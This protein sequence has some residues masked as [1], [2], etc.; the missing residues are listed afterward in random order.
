MML[1][2]EQEYRSMAMQKSSGLSSMSFVNIRDSSAWKPWWPLTAWAPTL[3]CYDQHLSGR[4]EMGIRI[5]RYRQLPV[6]SPSI[7]IW[8]HS[9]IELLAIHNHSR[10]LERGS[11]RINIRTFIH[12]ITC[13]PAIIQHDRG[14]ASKP[15]RDDRTVVFIRPLLESV[16]RL[17]FR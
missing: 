13:R 11:T 4:R 9:L 17:R 7:P 5:W 16:P 14:I 2:T 10:N 1:T 3:K 6:Q 8:Q 15:H 12:Q